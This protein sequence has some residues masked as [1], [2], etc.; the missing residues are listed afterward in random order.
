MLVRSSGGGATAADL[1]TFGF[2]IIR[3]ADETERGRGI[4]N[5]YDEAAA[6][7][8]GA[9]SRLGVRPRWGRCATSSAREITA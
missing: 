6:F 5:R 3:P 4:T 9:F 2:S 1:G 8:L 7:V